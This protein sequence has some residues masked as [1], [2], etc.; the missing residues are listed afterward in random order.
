MLQ[1]TEIVDLQD[2]TL[3]IFRFPRSCT[4]AQIRDIAGHCRRSGCI[5]ADIAVD[6]LA[7]LWP[8]RL[9]RTDLHNIIAATPHEGTEA[10]FWSRAERRAAIDSLVD[11]RL[12]SAGPDRVATD[13]LAAED[14]VWRILGADT[15][16]HLA[17]IQRFV[18]TEPGVLAS[19]RKGNHE[20]VL[21]FID[22]MAG[23]S[24]GDPSP[25]THPD[26]DEPWPG[27]R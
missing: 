8:E 13:Y 1:V 27:L 15:P 25:T 4:P 16:G 17:I 20:K 10:R 23:W 14:P 24:P 6:V 9:S 5:S 12:K 2:G 26:L 3:A 18:D 21:A 19:I 7:T 11:F 22:A